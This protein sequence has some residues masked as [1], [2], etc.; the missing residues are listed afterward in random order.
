MTKPQVDHI[1]PRSAGGSHDLVNLAASCNQCN[2]TKIGDVNPYLIEW[3]IDAHAGV[4]E[5]DAQFSR[6]LIRAFT[7]TKDRVRAINEWLAANAA[8]ER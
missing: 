7:R 4:D 2:A 5:A 1:L 6:Y 3:T 8:P